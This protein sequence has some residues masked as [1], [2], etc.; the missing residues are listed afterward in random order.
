M[1]THG[2]MT[3]HKDIDAMMTW[4]S[5]FRVPSTGIQWLERDLVEKNLLRRRSK[6]DSKDVPKA[7]PF[8]ENM[9]WCPTRMGSIRRAHVS[10]GHAH[11]LFSETLQG[12]NFHDW[13]HELPQLIVIHHM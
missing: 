6:T 5:F 4:C 3:S 8:K 12:R 2:A 7:V 13:P 10:V 11:W 1:L 9:S